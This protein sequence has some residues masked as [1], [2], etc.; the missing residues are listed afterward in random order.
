M[1]WLI[2]LLVVPAIVVPVV[3]LGGFAGCSF[4]APST[5]P[6]K[7]T[8]LRATPVSVSII[9][10]FWDN[11][12]IEP[13]SF[14]V[15]RVRAGQSPAPGAFMLFGAISTALRDSGLEE[16]TTYLYR[17]KAVRTSDNAESLFTLRVSESTFGL[18]FAATLGLDT[19][20]LEG[21]CIV[22]RIEP[23][24][25]LRSG[26]R[27]SITIRGAT[28]GPLALDRIFIS[29][30]AASGDPYDSGAD[31][32]LVASS[33]VVP[34]NTPVRLPT[35]EYVLDRFRPLL[36]A[37]DVSAAPG[38]GNA[39]FFDPAPGTIAYVK[40]AVAEAATADRLPS[41]A[42]PGAPPYEVASGNIYFVERIEVTP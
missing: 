42:N 6:E 25:L 26:T 38:S 7:P 9:D 39:R 1:E 3:L 33:V 15:E 10:L 2:L 20:G 21:F 14:I 5:V 37:F 27:V 28:T 16:S 4:E 32:K 13:V 41:A 36:I 8:N 40:P 22:Q 29:Q 18:T 19:G 24:R 31:L 12:N 17:V 11:P 30:A 23:A 35:I 34:A